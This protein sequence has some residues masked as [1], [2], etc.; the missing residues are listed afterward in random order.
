MFEAADGGTVFLDEIG[1]ISPKVQLALLR[2]LQEAEITRLGESTPTKVDVRVIAATNKNLPQQVAEE[3]F[4][5][6]LMYRIRIAVIELPALRDRRSDIPILTS[7]FIQEASSVFDK[8]VDGVGADAMAA[9]MSHSWPGNV[10]ELKNVI[11]VATI[12]CRS[13]IVELHDFPPEFASATGTTAT[14]CDPQ[15]SERER[16]CAALRVAH[17][18]KA[19]A[20]RSL[21][22]SRATFYRR[23]LSL[24]IDFHDE[25]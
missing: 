20:A 1:D 23:L 7:A 12:R 5:A 18:N 16:I 19:A 22:M 6:D 8:S 24:D 13:N 14:P 10:R 15:E 4:R 21:G 17:G 11:E 9:L 25:G 3:R 2:V